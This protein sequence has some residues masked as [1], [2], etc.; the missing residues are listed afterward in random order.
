MITVKAL[1]TISGQVAS[2]PA[3]YL[4]HPVLGKNLVAVEDKAKSYAPELYKSKS[5]DEFIAA[6]KR[7]R[8][9]KDEREEEAV[10]TVAFES[11]DISTDE[12][13]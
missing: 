7:G 2:V 11:D 3:K 1:N 4:G 8:K 6:P 10:E 5:A 12:D 9:A 13:N